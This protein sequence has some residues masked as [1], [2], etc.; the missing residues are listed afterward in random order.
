MGSSP[1]AETSTLRMPRA[2][3]CPAKDPRLEHD[4]QKIA[5]SQSVPCER[6]TE[7]RF[8]RACE[9]SHTHRSAQRLRCRPMSQDT[10]IFV[11][12]GGRGNDTCPI[13]RLPH[14]SAP[15]Q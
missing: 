7:E 15:V 8:Q 5:P 12:H 2:P 11:G 9:D 6:I 10:L 14:A 4:K 3:R 13:L 1:A